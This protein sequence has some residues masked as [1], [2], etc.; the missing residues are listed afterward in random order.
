M[1]SSKAG[2]GPEAGRLH[3]GE[4]LLWVAWFIFGVIFLGIWSG[5]AS[6][7]RPLEFGLSDPV[8]VFVLSVTLLQTGMTFSLNLRRS[9]ASISLIVAWAFLDLITNALLS[10][11]VLAAAS[12]P[13]W[14][15]SK[16]WIIK[17]V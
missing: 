4:C 2:S 1:G 8:V 6:F 14:F 15:L 7:N 3:G 17:P 16:L 13:V 5:M 11:L 12:V 9:G 10:C